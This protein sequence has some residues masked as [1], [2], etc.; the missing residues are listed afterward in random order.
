MSVDDLNRGEL[1]PPQATDAGYDSA[2]KTPQQ[3]E[4]DI[5]DTREQLGEILDEL[6]RRLAPRQ[7]LERGFDMLKDTM[8]GDGGGIGEVIRSHPVPLALIGMGL[9]W[10]LV[11]NTTRDRLGDYGSS[12]KNRIT[13]AMQGASE[14]VGEVAGQV[15]EKVTG[16]AA[17]AASS[18][19]ASSSPYSTDMA[20]YAY[21]R[22][23]SGQAMDQARQAASSATDTAQQMV[24][25]AQEAGRQA[26]NRAADYTGQAST[27]LH[28]ARDRF[29]ELIEDHPIAIGAMGFLAGAVM[30]LLL[31]RSDIEE[32][33]V[34]PA[35]EDLR[36]Q[37]ASLG[38]DAVERAQQ[39]AERTVDAAVGAVK[40]AVNEAGAAAAGKAGGASGGG[41]NHVASG[42]SAASAGT[43]HPAGSGP[44]QVGAGADRGTAGHVA[45]GMS[46]AGSGGARPMGSGPGHSGA[47][48][49]SASKED[50]QQKAH[51]AEGMSGSGKSQS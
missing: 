33:V 10:I 27:Q 30:A 35:S 36:E 9:G 18:A 8:S 49:R 11:S 51:I 32:K 38:R 48:Q 13:D 25:R 39:V 28:Q 6:E 2:G 26:L 14:R 4:E 22:Q 5:V 12:V 29:T 19:D 7:L 1:I 3:I 34:G 47:G 31:P 24:G 50:E 15:R 44:G 16:A 41:L 46:E 37:A 45:S 23:K 42:M 21:A 40:E 17:H 20:G 43:A